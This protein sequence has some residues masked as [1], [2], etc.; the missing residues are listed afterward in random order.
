LQKRVKLETLPGEESEMAPK[1]DLSF[2]YFLTKTW[3]LRMSTFQ[4]WMQP[5]KSPL[6][7]T[8]PLKPT[9][10]SRLEGSLN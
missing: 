1:C 10:R 4:K 7:I 3:L 5:E 9:Q 6:A 8:D 2:R